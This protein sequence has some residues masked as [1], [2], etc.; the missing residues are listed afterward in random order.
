V[1]T[2]SLARISGL[3][4]LAVILAAPSESSADP[5]I[6]GPGE[7]TL[8][9][10]W[11][12][13]W[14][15]GD[16]DD[17]W[18]ETRV[19]NPQTGQDEVTLRT[20]RDDDEFPINVGVTGEWRLRF[21]IESV[22]AGCR[23]TCDPANILHVIRFNDPNRPDD[24]IFEI[25]LR[26]NNTNSDLTLR[27][28]HHQSTL[29]VLKPPSNEP[30]FSCL[31][32]TCLFAWGA[33][34]EAVTGTPFHYFV[35]KPTNGFDPFLGRRS[36]FVST[37]FDAAKAVWDVAPPTDYDCRPF[38]VDSVTTA[39]LPIF[40]EPF[41][42]LTLSQM[43][44]VGP[45]ACG[46]HGS[47]TAS[48]FGQAGFGYMKAYAGL[49]AIQAPAT[50]LGQP[51]SKTVYGVGGAADVLF[52]TSVPSGSAFP[53]PVITSNLNATNFAEFTFTVSGRPLIPTGNAKT[54]SG[55][56]FRGGGAPCSAAPN[57]PHDSQDWT[58][59][60]SSTT[61]PPIRVPY[62]PNYPLR[63]AFELAAAVTAAADDTSTAPAYDAQ[64]SADFSSTATLTG[65]RAF[66]GTPENPGREITNFRVMSL[67]GAQYNQHGA[68]MNVSLAAEP[69]TYQTGS[70]GKMKVTIMADGD[71]DPSTAVDVTSLTF[72][73]IGTEPSL[74]FCDQNQRPIRAQ[75]RSLICHF[76]RSRTN[77]SRTSSVGV[78]QGKLK[79]GHYFQG[80][81]L[82]DVR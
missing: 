20:N 60:M 7:I 54:L 78:L 63:A 22:P 35:A 68:V 27:L 13:V 67:S 17:Y 36:P 82:I 62:D 16:A 6:T 14:V 77:L 71:F 38:T 37:S 44:N 51:W 8:S 65:I 15:H 5:T 47:I 32:T 72:G 50:V 25:L 1:T 74:A 58:G 11:S 41:N 49:N 76:E 75:A 43:R 52:I 48:M 28:E 34:A 23:A 64:V 66:E 55:F 19:R 79:D 12:L 53:P 18:I 61:L 26:T 2:D 29:P 73:V 70:Q 10:K 31:G 69:E 40:D 33:V 59:A 21:E 45:I 9:G 3:I 24:E 4:A 30:S 39:W 42:T 81:Q 57:C 56:F 46:G 80:T